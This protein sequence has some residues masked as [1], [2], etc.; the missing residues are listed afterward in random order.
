MCCIDAIQYATCNA[1]AVVA[2]CIALHTPLGVQCNATSQRLTCNC[3]CVKMYTDVREAIRIASS[4]EMETYM[5]LTRKMLKAMGIE[6]EKIDQIIEAHTEVTD[7][8]KGERD[9]YRAEAEQVGDIQKELDELKA[10]G[11][12]GFQAKYEKE[13]Q[14]FEDYKA[15]I[16]GE[17]A[18]EEKRALYRALLTEAGIDSKRIDAVMKVADLESV[19]VKDGKIEGVKEL[20]DSIKAEWADFIVTPGKK[21]SKVDNP[22]GNEPDPSASKPSSLA[23]ALKQKYNVPN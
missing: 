15:Q 7:A 16:A 1:R 14:A 12:G 4:E 20:T 22:P 18:A 3:E 2:C 10:K 21:G 5:A 11:D 13:H 19:T 8:L 6:D 17:K 23:D 9:K